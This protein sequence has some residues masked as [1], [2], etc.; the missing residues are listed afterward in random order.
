MHDDNALIEGRLSRILGRLRAAIHSERAPVEIAA[1]RVDGEPV[2]VPRGLSGAYRPARV[3][4][5][6]GPPWGTT[7]FR[8]R[9]T[10]PDGWAGR[11][12]EAL[13]DIG[14]GGGTGFQAEGLV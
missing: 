13:I 3:G 9:A 10:V 6:W 11:T 12:V 14:F 5:R 2:P 7:W 1:W 8:V 4:D